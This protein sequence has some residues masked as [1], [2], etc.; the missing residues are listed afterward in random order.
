[1]LIRQILF[2][3]SF[4]KPFDPAYIACDNFILVPN[5]KVYNMMSYVTA[6]T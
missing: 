4:G 2:Q 3:N 1:M 5:S 6:Y